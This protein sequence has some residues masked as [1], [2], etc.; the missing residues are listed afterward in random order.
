MP[1]QIRKLW[2]RP[3][4]ITGC[5][6]LLDLG[7]GG[8]PTQSLRGSHFVS[9]NV[10]WVN[11]ARERG[12]ADAVDSLADL[13]DVSFDAAVYAPAP[14]ETK[15]RVFEWID[16][17]HSRLAE[18]GRFYLGGERHRGVESYRR[19]AEDVFGSATKVRQVGRRRVY[20]ARKGRRSGVAE[21][22]TSY[23]FECSIQGD[24]FS[25]VTRA[26]VFSRDHVDPGTRLLL[27]AIPPCQG[28]A[29]LDVGC[30]Y[31]ALGIALARRGAI[32]TM[33][34]VDVRSTRCAE[35]NAKASGASTSIVT[36]D[37]Y[38]G[39]EGHRFDVIVSN[40]PFHSGLSFARPF[41]EGARRHLNPGGRIWLVVMRK[42]PY[43]L[44]LERYIGE[45]RTAVDEGGYRVLNATLSDSLGA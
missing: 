20:C 43:T 10:K 45:V 42:E 15:P 14:A 26:G 22:Q 40:P 32:V 12:P 39:V 41:V 24:S 2:I 1:K 4:D 25:F 7:D 11:Q 8:P 34:D 44:Q 23:R 6:R 21:I 29:L 19:R 13:P 30:G 33:T 37:L 38:D 9:S 5:D 16:G 35:E 17:V 18:G 27:D 28:K 3:E 36:A 31:G